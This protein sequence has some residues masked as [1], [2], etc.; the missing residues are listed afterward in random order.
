MTIT[1]AARA[2]SRDHSF[3][4]Y[5]DTLIALFP[6]CKRS[7]H[8]DTACT[9]K[10]LDVVTHSGM[11]ISVLFESTSTQIDDSSSF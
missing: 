8:R 7:N 9:I 1:D 2:S 3:K 4:I 5:R 10:H 6:H 11:S